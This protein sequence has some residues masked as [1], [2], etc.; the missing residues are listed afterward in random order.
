MENGEKSIQVPGVSLLNNLEKFYSHAPRKRGERERETNERNAFKKKK[1]PA[2][3]GA[4]GIP[5]RQK[6]EKRK[7]TS[8]A[9]LFDAISQEEEGKEKHADEK[10]DW[11]KKKGTPK[12][13]RCK[14]A[15]SANAQKG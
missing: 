1:K 2:Q 9:R 13:I 11:T 6:E 7:K 8:H 3:E 10:T 14:A 12:A 4:G 5:C 15:S